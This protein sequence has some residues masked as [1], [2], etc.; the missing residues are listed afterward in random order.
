MEVSLTH[1]NIKGLATGL[2]AALALALGVVASPVSATSITSE[3]ERRLNSEQAQEILESANATTPVLQ[4]FYT[5]RGFQPAWVSENGAGA[6]AMDIADMLGRSNLH[7][8]DHSDYRAEEIQ[9]LLKTKDAASLAKLDMLISMAVVEYTLDSQ[10]GR[11][12][13]TESAKGI[14]IEPEA[15]MPLETLIEAAWAEDPRAFLRAQAPQSFE[16]VRLKSAFADYRAL[17]KSGGWN[18]VPESETLKLDMQ[19]PEVEAVRRRLMKTGDLESLGDDPQ[20]FDETLENAVKHFQK[21]HGLDEDGAVG[22]MTRAAMNVPVEARLQQMILNMERRRWMPDDLGESYVF[23]N[24]ADFELKVVDGPKTIHDD[25]VVVGTRYHKTPIFSDEISYIVIN[26]YWHITPSI[27][28]NEMLP[29]IQED[30]DYFAKKRIKVL[31]D[32]SENATILDP[33][34]IDWQQHSR[35]SFPYKLRQE[36][37]EGNALGRIKFIFPNSHNIYLH[38]TPA[39]DLFSRSVRSFSHGCI[40]VYQP[41]ELA[42]VLLR[43]DPNWSAQKIE[44]AV[45]SGERQIVN[46]KVK[47][48]VHLTYLTAWV[49]KDGTVHFRD[50]IYGRD[51]VLAEALGTERMSAELVQ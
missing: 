23:V 41:L 50:D 49:N 19:G 42:R 6:R 2:A 38:D 25:R 12:S 7:G 40:R 51:A 22:K 37:G 31:S 28:R 20:L 34:Q 33:Q 26:P 13:P 44:A 18:Q 15:D 3:I 8:L 45:A 43:N 9:N 4:A 35:S 39:R 48:P 10:V 17:A 27:A 36:P 21:R 11:V 24:L 32:W 30:P 1:T 16:Y 46:L 14:F 5:A 29:K 47:I